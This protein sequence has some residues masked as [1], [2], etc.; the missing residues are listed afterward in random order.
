MATAPGWDVHR[1]EKGSSLPPVVTQQELLLGS[2]NGAQQ[3][4]PLWTCA[5]EMAIE[6]GCLSGKGC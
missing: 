3:H 1:V 6:K 2:G 5:E 4:L